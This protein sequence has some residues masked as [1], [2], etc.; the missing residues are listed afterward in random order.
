MI[1]LRLV[2]ASSARHKKPYVYNHKH[3]INQQGFGLAEATY[4]NDT[5]VPK[6]K[7]LKHILT[8]SDVRLKFV[9]HSE[10]KDRD[11]FC[12]CNLHAAGY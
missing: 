4:T 9:M 8:V 5:T 11:Q 3:L 1:T 12:K 6:A 10:E 2:L 7:R